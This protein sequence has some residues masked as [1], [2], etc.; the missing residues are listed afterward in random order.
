MP[1]TPSKRRRV[2]NDAAANS[3]LTPKKTAASKLRN[4]I[5]IDADNSARRKSSRR[6][7]ERSAR[8]V[9]ADS[10][11]ES[12]LAEEDELAQEIL[13]EDDGDDRSDSDGMLLEPET[14]SKR[15]RPRKKRQKERSPSPPRD[16][17]PHE[18]YF[19]DNRPGG[20]KTSNST[21]ASV[22]L[23]T[24]DQFFDKIKSY[25]NPHQSELDFLHTLHSQAFEQW[26]F[27]LDEGFNLCFYGW[28]SKRSLLLDFAE[29]LANVDEQFKILVINGYNPVITLRDIL[30]TVASVIPGLSNPSLKLGAQPAE[31]LHT[32]MKGLNDLPSIDRIILVIHCIDAIPMRRPAVQNALARLATSTSI[33]LIASADTRTFPIMWDASLA[34]QLNWLY[35]DVTTFQPYD[36]EISGGN[37]AAGVVDEVNSLFGRTGRKMQGKEGVMYVLKSLTESARKL[38]KLIIL[39]LL[40]A[41]VVEDAGLSADEDFDGDTGAGDMRVGIDFRTLYQKSTSKFIATNEQTFRALLR[42]FYDH[43]ML[44]SRKDA[45]G[46]EVF[47]IPFRKEEM[48]T[49]QEGLADVPF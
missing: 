14:P 38:Y 30:H 37:G 36:L 18:Q 42:E 22:S 47:A 16:L 21:L 9:V 4:D 34:A 11:D 39:E 25:E 17:P 6:L 35:H 15:G 7:I 8:Q 49:I 28:G 1:E 31:M 32:V 24:H 33:R 43:E 12:E 2:I 10:D 13:G 46:G 29:H 20:T 45:L 40:S 41:D 19:Y 3:K 5:A 27:E 48:Y 26:Q 44:V 23:P